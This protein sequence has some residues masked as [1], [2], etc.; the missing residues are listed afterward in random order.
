MMPLDGPDLARI[1]RRSGF[2]QMTPIIMVS[3]D[4]S[5]SAISDGFA[6]GA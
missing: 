6:A 2:N 5:T 4:Q 3:D 1:A